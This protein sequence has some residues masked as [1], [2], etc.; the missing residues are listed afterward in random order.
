MNYQIT[1]CAL[2]IS[3]EPCADTIFEDIIQLTNILLFRQKRTFQHHTL[4]Y[5]WKETRTS[6][7]H[8]R[9]FIPSLLLC[10]HLEIGQK[11]K[12]KKETM[13]LNAWHSENSFPRDFTWIKHISMQQLN[14]SQLIP[15]STVSIFWTSHCSYPF[16]QKLLSKK[17][18]HFSSAIR[19][20]FLPFDA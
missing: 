18:R 5:F 17:R 2:Y 11:R 7:K 15:S 14:L 12:R 1:S 20:P 9:L 4:L 13:F 3:V 19:T 16:V 10:M 8:F 6:K